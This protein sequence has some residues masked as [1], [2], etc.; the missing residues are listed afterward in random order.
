LKSFIK[1]GNNKCTGN[2]LRAYNQNYYVESFG[3]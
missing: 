2:D 1:N 3:W